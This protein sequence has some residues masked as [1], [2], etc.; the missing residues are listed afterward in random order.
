MS[1]PEIPI[2]PPVPAL[3]P[4][5]VPDVPSLAAP[6]DP[7]LGDSETLGHHGYT[8]DPTFIPKHS[9]ETVNTEGFVDP[10]AFGEY[11][12]YI[13][14]RHKRGSNAVWVDGHVSF[15]T[16][17]EVYRDN[18]YWNGLGREDERLD[19]HVEQRFG[20]G[21]FRYQAQLDRLP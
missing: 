2:A 9:L 11:R 21:A 1:D 13:S 7:D 3:D 14:D 20:T 15:I 17:A 8:L 12:S 18:R 10:Y 16:P 4:P 6:P 19:P 5:P